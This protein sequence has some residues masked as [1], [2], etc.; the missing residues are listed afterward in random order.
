MNRIYKEQFLRKISNCAIGTKTCYI[1]TIGIYST[2]IGN[3]EPTAENVKLFIQNLKDRNRA[4]TSVNRHLAAI[5]TF[6]KANKLVWDDELKASPVDLYDTNTP[7]ISPENAKKIIVA[8]K[9]RGC[10]SDM[11]Y[12]AIATIYG[13]RVSELAILNEN[14]IDID[15]NTILLEANK[16]GV[17][18]KHLIPEEIYFIKDYEFEEQST[19][20]LNTL[21][22][23]ICLLSNYARQDGE[24]WHSPRRGIITGLVENR[25]TREAINAFMRW[26]PRDMVERY[27][28]QGLTAEVSDRKI[29]EKHPFLPFWREERS[30]F[31]SN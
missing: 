19:T 17:S 13:V 3:K 9:E 7:T 2:F 27:Y 21:F 12:L 4:V 26:A 28:Q 18:R 14:S 20:T 8:T 10:L 22:H 1:S 16:G 24:A 25:A 23:K 6:F 5:K 30:S 29:F 31:V 15:K 11:A